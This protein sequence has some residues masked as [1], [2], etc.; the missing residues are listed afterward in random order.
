MV[1]RGLWCGSG[2]MGSCLSS[3]LSLFYSNMTGATCTSLWCGGVNSQVGECLVRGEGHRLKNLLGRYARW[4]G[5]SGTLKSWL[6]QTAGVGRTPQGE[7]GLVTIE[8]LSK[9]G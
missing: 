5:S 4:K 1:L 9:R 7:R 8:G 6:T 2:K 3:S